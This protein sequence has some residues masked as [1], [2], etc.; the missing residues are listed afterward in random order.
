MTSLGRS[1]LSLQSSNRT[2]SD[3]SILIMN[4]IADQLVDT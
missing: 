2:G 4:Y 3:V 1:Q